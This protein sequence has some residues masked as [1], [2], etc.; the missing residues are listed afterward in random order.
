MEEGKIAVLL[1]LLLIIKVNLRY[2]ARSHVYVYVPV[3]F[4]PYIAV[5]FSAVAARRCYRAP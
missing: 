1:L 4:S 5:R 2:V 3:P